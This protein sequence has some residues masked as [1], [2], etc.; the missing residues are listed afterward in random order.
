MIKNIIKF[1]LK[2]IIINYHFMKNEF[3]QNFCNKKDNYEEQSKN[4]EI[5]EFFYEKL[6]R[7]NRIS[8]FG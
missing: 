1:N 6:F 4:I 5:D 2:I 7:C 8:R 3:L